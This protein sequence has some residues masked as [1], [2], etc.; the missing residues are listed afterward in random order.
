MSKKLKDGTELAVRFITWD[1]NWVADA[2]IIFYQGIRRFCVYNHK[3]G[4]HDIVSKVVDDYVNKGI[5]AIWTPEILKEFE[6]R[7]WDVKSFE[8]RPGN[9]WE[10]VYKI[11][12]KS[13]GTFVAK[14]ISKTEITPTA[15]EAVT[16]NG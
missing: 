3:D 9:R 13:D 16:A 1:A 14:R 5:G 12:E 2:P 7:K 11:S 4:F 15:A 10:C 8:T 6:W